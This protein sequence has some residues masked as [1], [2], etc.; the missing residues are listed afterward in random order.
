[1][2]LRPYPAYKESGLPWLGRVP[3][4]WDLLRAKYLMREMDIRAKDESG[5]LLSVSQYSGV[6]KRR[7]REGS[8]DPDTRSSSLFGYKVAKPGNLVSNIMLA[9]NGSLGIA[10][11]EGLVS[12]AYCVYRICIGE[13]WFFH[14]LLRSPAYKAEIKRRSRGVVDSRLRLYTDDFFRIPML[15]PNLRE[16]Q[17]IVR[18]VRDLDEKVHRFI[19]NRRRLIEVL[20]EQ[21]QA[22]INRAVTRGLDPDAPFKSSGIDWLGDIPGHWMRVPLKHVARVQTGITLGKNYRSQRLEERPYL[23]VANV[24]VGQVDL[25]QVKTVMVPPS[26]IPGSELR[27]GDVLMTEGGDIDK[28]G[29]GCVWKNEIEGCLHQNHIFAV[30]VSQDRIIPEYLVALMASR[31]GRIYF[32]ITAKRTTNLASTNSTTLG[33]FPLILPSIDEQ[34]RILTNIEF[35]TA[36]LEALLTKAAREIDLIREYRTRLISDVVTG[37]VDVRH[38][39]PAPGSQDLE[40]T[41]ASL[42]PLEDDIADGVIDDEEPFNEPE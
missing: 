35:E 38:L 12:P 40:E 9:W 28:L 14:H 21:K 3:K 22:I 7:P 4:H 1:M 13:P 36:E 23:R 31:H 34:R 42:E 33:A 15:L 11:M 10:P 37:K 25:R 30:R 26:E 6:T 16:Q 29:R 19:R 41:V 39:A 17:A 18:F 32:E 8:E 2:T 20:N 24:Q 5:T 27:F